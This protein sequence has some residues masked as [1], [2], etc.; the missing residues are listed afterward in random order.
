MIAGAPSCASACRRP[1]RSDVEVAV[2]AVLN[3][4]DAKCLDRE[5]WLSAVVQSLQSEIRRERDRKDAAA[6]A[7]LPSLYTECEGAS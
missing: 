4:G 5:S 3:D 7:E 2:V 1:S 6:R